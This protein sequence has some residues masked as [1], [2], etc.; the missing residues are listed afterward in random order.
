MARLDL[1]NARVAARRSRLL[2]ARGLRELALR[3]GLAARLEALR[4]GPWGAGLPD[5]A[6]PPLGEVEAALRESQ[7]REAAWLAGLAEGA[8]AGRALRALLA[9]DDADAVK[10]LLRGVAAAAPPERILAAAPASPGLPAA[11]LARAAAAGGVAGAVA[12]LRASG[13]PLAPALAAAL[14]A[15]GGWG[16]AR[17]EAAADQAAAAAAWRVARG[18]G[19]DGAALAHHLAERADAWN[20]R[21][22]LAVAGA[23]PRAQ[24][25]RDLVH[26]GGTRLPPAVAA[27]LLGAPHEAVHAAVAAAWPGL[28]AALG[29]PAAAELA[30]E[31]RLLVAARRA[32]RAAPLSLA[33]P[34]AYL[35]ERRAEGRRIALLLR[36]DAFA[37]PADEVLGLLEAAA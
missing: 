21:L 8:A 25:A 27:P 9:L 20:A 18:A 13:H 17:L 30:L 35:L 10:A 19:A 32:A 6:A 15:P 29:D 37:L 1:L 23:G 36:A 22:L 33:V 4:A 7:R 5:G 31:R 28:A 14:E 34:I 11:L 3:A 24:E 16:L 26:P 12:A 2:G